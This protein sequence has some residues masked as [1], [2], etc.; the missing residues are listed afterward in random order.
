[1]IFR[2]D[3]KLTAKIYKGEKYYLAK[4]PE[5]G[6]FTQGKTREEAKRNLKE[7][8]AVHIKALADYAIEH[9]SVNLERAHQ[10]KSK[11]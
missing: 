7:A 6:V 11:Q 8:L 1:M 4:I 10:V 9:G 2:R 5:L 3:M